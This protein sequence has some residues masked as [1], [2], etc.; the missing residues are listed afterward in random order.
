MNLLNLLLIYHLLTV[1]SNIEYK[2]CTI[3]N[4]LSIVVFK[5]SFYNF[6]HYL[7][8]NH[9]CA[10]QFSCIKI[11]CKQNKIYSIHPFKICRS[12]RPHCS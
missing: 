4:E 10:T 3:K 5:G 9:F 12:M 1:I 8:K 11:F 6:R 7:K 2:W